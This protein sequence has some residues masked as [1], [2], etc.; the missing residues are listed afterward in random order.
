MCYAM[1]SI[2]VL[3]FIVWAH[4]RNRYI[5]VR[6]KLRYMLEQL[7]NDFVVHNSSFINKNK[8]LYWENQQNKY[9]QSAGNWKYLKIEV[10]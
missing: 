10:N 6:Y 4:F 7:F 9:N 8:P 5:M 2:G 1:L 3:G